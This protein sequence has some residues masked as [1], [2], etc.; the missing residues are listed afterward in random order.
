MTNRMAM[1]AAGALGLF[2]SACETVG[3]A[4]GAS[5]GAPTTAPGLEGGYTYPAPSGSEVVS[6]IVNNELESPPFEVRLQMVSGLT[7]A[8]ASRPYP[9]LALVVTEGDAHETL[10][11]LDAG[12]LEVGTPYQAR[13]MVSQMSA[14]VRNN[15]LFEQYG[16]E[17]YASVFDL[18]KL[19][20]FE[21]VII[22]NGD[23]F[24]YAFL[25][26]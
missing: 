5:A 25:I 3:A 23:D 2:C 21:R 7:Q 11:F 10:V 14:A 13:A 17:A 15:P 24:A 26:E 20:G 16:V 19:A 9:P 4:S 6:T 18:F 1:A 12:R 22:T 8:L